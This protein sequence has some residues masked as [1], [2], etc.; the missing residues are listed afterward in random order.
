MQTFLF[1]LP[2]VLAYTVVVVWA[3]RKIA[4]FV[5]D[6]Y[7]PMET[8]PYGILQTVADLLKMLQK[9]NIVPYKVRKWPFLIAPLIIFIAIFTGFSV[10]PLSP[11]LGGAG[12]ESGIVLLLGVVT[13]DIMGI[14]LAGW[15]SNSKFSVYGALRSVAQLVSYE[16]PLTLSVLAV[17]VISQSLNLQEITLLQSKW[18][19]SPA[20]LFYLPAA[21][22]REL[23]GFLTW[24]I[25]THPL[26]IPAFIIFFITTLAE[27]NRAPFDL[28]EAE[29]ELVGGYHTEY[30]GFRWGLFMLGEYTMMLLTAFV[31]AILFF[32][33]WNSPF[34]NV[35]SFTL[36]DW[37]M[38]VEGTVWREIAGAFWL[39]LKMLV[40]VFFQIM[41]RWTYPRV[42]IDQL[43]SLCWKYLTPA[44][45]IIL[46]L[47]AIIEIL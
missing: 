36:Y 12:L 38:G 24:N 30:S 33:G 16:V 6:R 37:T 40:I 9:E 7:G 8:G 31:G 46:I 39:I 13:L 14:I 29:A 19:E 17:L 43:M 23:G 11:S 28:P 32:G 47:N 35:G 21:E 18:A 10:V 41:A 5:Q 20:Y 34:P 2:F 44:A 26:L 4:G 42:R 45:L 1:F 22:V 15:G 3:E 25:F 27:S